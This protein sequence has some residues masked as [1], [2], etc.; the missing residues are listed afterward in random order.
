MRA[1]AEMLKHFLRK[2]FPS[3]V[4]FKDGSY[5]E[6]F[7][8]EAILYVENNGR[9]MEIACF[10]Q[11]GRVKGRVLRASHIDYWDSPHK[12]ECVTPQ[13]KEEILQK[14]VEYCRKRNIPI[15]IT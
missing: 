3:R 14:I 8:R 2:I 11:K 6:F 15:E 4:L 5:I 10:F 12:A 7:N 1:L 13:K 9:Q